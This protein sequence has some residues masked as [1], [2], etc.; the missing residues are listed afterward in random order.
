M[1]A[2][3]SA[4]SALHQIWVV[5]ARP[6]PPAGDLRMAVP[7]LRLFLSALGARGSVDASAAR[8]LARYGARPPP[9]FAGGAAGET[10]LDFAAFS[11]LVAQEALGPTAASEGRGGGGPAGAELLRVFARADADGDGALSSAEVAALLGADG[12]PVSDAEVGAVMEEA[13]AGGGGRG[14]SLAQ[15]LHVNETQTR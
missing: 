3:T 13:G 15:F 10:T 4:A 9:G 14:L 7:E 1:S 11:L 6:V 5:F 2:P 8:L 12:R